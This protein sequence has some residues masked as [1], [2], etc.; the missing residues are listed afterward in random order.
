MQNCDESNVAQA[1]YSPINKVV[2]AFAEITID[3]KL[4]WYGA[5]RDVFGRY[6][7]K[8]AKQTV[9]VAVRLVQC[10]AVYS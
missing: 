8:V 3:A 9:D 4:D 5:P 6:L 1:H 7:G 2:L 10:V